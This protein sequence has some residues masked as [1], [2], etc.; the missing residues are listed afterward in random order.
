MTNPAEGSRR[1]QGRR[2]WLHARA[3][4]T[5]ADVSPPRPPPPG[6]ARGPR[7]LVLGGAGQLGWDLA[8][9]CGPET[10][11]LRR[12]DLDIRDAGAVRAMVAAWADHQPPGSS[13]V[14]VNAAAWTDVDAAEAEE[15]AAGAVNVTG[16]A[17]LAGA[18]E[19][20]GATLIHVSTDYVFAGDEVRPYD[21]ADRPGPVC[22][23][24]RTKLAGEEAVRSLTPRHYV[25]RTS[26]VYGAAGHNF[27][28]TIARLERERETLRVV[29]DQRGSPTWS[30]DLAAGLVALAS[31][32]VP[33]GLYH[34]AGAGDTTWWGLA[35]AVFEE[36]GADPARVLPCTTSELSLKA[37]RPAYSVLSDRAWHNV[38][39]SPLPHWRDALAGAFAV[40]GEA[41]RP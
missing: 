34:L 28:K 39:L 26:W 30:R 33:Y 22:A 20:A 8:R 10:T 37:P 17:N 5:L 24:G 4:A 2:G 35:R 29:D 6:P 21:V 14:I 41:L 36:L 1:N 18:T 32:G 40:D 31:S 19:A 9:L 23:Y 11:S 7:L 3:D 16:A 27:V 13:L 15:E 25:V 12:K 38:G